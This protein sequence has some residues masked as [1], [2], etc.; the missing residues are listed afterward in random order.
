MVIRRGPSKSVATILWNRRDDSFQL[1]QWLR[2][3][4][5]ERRSDLSADGEHLLY[6]AMNGRWKS[7][8]RGAW[9]AVSRAPY[10]KAIVLLGKGDCWNGGG[11]WTGKRTY[12]LNDG[13]GHV[14]LREDNSVRRD[15]RYHPDDFFGSE[16]LGVYFPRLMRDGWTLETAVPERSH[17]QR[18]YRFRKP[19]P[20]G[21]T[22]FKLAHSQFGAP[23][24]KGC[25]WDEHALVSPNGD[26]IA[27]PTWEWAEL[28]HQRLVWAERGR[29]FASAVKKRGL[30]SP[31]ELQDFNDMTF[32]AIAAPY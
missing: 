30:G 31:I 23:E 15:E 22:L 4:I 17:S 1:G 18:T 25:Y 24:G 12:W 8:T 26:T 16:C 10:L 2:G 28:D 29:L 21:W 13:Y 3:R 7:E 19:L 11:L 5:Y 14:P 6:F 9:T 27:C 20:N 32:T